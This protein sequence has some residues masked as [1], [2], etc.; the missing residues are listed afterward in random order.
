M[1][2]RRSYT[3]DELAHEAGIPS[4]SIRYYQTLGLLPPPRVE[5]R[6]GYYDGSHVGRLELIKELQGEGLNLQAIGWLLGGSARVDSEELRE[7]KRAI[8]DGWM[9]TEPEERSTEE[10]VA[11]LGQDSID[12]ED[13]R[14][15]QELGLTEPT[16]E[17]D[18]W[19]VL[20]PAVLNA[21]QELAQIGM[22]MPPSRALDVL[23]LM[24]EHVRTVADAFV[25]IFDE[26]VLAPWDARGRPAEEWP[27]V[28]A[29]VDRMRPLAG[30]ALLS[31]FH[32]AMAEAV[33]ERIGG[34]RPDDPDA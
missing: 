31:V 26:T 2:R 28:R 5:G 24:R 17:E 29:A 33:A 32:Q 11:S 6:T 9:S 13:V 22:S 3:I 16:E 12:A 7:L 25:E 8:L 30:E 10:I 14:R 34:M 20:L 15:A 27:D 21:G 4:R 18:T 19:R 1:R 23:E